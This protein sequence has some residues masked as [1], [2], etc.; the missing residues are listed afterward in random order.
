MNLRYSQNNDKPAKNK[1]R[2]RS[3]GKKADSKDKGTYT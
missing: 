1:K 2:L 3:L